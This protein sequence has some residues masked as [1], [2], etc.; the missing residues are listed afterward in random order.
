MTGSAWQMDD[1]GAWAALP[2]EED[3]GEAPGKGSPIKPAL[4][5][6]GRQNVFHSVMLRIAG[7]RKDFETADV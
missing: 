1:E 7:P 4:R 6:R 5:I 3:G 2:L